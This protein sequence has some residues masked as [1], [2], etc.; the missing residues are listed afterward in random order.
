MMQI[1][2]FD[3]FLDIVRDVRTEVIAARAQFAGGQFLVADIIKQQGLHGIDVAAAAPV[4]FVLDHVEK[5]A[6]QPLNQPQSIEIGRPDLGKPGARLRGLAFQGTHHRINLVFCGGIPTGA[7]MQPKYESEM[8]TSL[9]NTLN[10]SFI[11]F[12]K[13][14][15]K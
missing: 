14:N 1:A 11:L 6:M 8:K 7:S 5:A 15:M 2:G 10:P 13:S 4:E 3:Q 12:S 9:S